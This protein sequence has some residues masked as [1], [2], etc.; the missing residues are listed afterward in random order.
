MENNLNVYSNNSVIRH[1]AK[2]KG[3]Q[4]PEAEIFQKLS[5]NL[6]QMDVLDIGIGGGRTTHFLMDKVKSYTGIDFSKGMIDFCKLKFKN[7]GENFALEVCD[8]RD[9]S[10]FP[11]EKFDLILFSFNGLDNINHEERI[12]SVSEIK[13]ICKK[14]GYFCF[15]SHN[16][17]N[18][19]G[20]FKI[21]FRWNAWKLLSAIFKIKRLRK[22]NE[23]QLN[24]LNKGADKILIYDNVYDFG[25]LT[26][27]IKPS[28]QVTQLKN[29]GFNQVEVYSLK[30]GKKIEE[31]D[32]TGIKDSWLYYLAK[33]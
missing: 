29:A 17:N 33:N 14:G 19:A 26:Y 7:G 18:L 12:K 31:K 32:L 5:N 10:I 30:T 11:D 6:K 24:A 22:L 23:S 15:S 25:L 3:L 16:L 9:L 13:R 28:S 8:V 1:Y 2:Y 27:Y 21:K 4:K 20:F